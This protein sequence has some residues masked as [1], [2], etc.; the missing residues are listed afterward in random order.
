MP[1]NSLDFYSDNWA[2]IMSR[3][4]LYDCKND[5]GQSLKLK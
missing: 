4:S 1:H 3:T 2:Q 5:D